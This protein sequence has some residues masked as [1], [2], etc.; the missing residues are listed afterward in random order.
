MVLKTRTVLVL[1]QNPEVFILLLNVLPRLSTSSYVHKL[2]VILAL[3]QGTHL[4]SIGDEEL[5]SF[6]SVTD[7][8]PTNLHIAISK[9]SG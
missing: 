1:A 4:V 5:Q 6:Q 3:F 7:P 8:F 9:N 2:V